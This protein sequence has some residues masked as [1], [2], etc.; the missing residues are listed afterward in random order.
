M[1]SFAYFV[2]GAACFMGMDEEDEREFFSRDG[3][4]AWK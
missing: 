3:S 4:E 1:A 2:G